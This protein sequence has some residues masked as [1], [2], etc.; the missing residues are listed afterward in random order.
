MSKDVARVIGMVI[1]VVSLGVFAFE[2][3]GKRRIL[4]RLQ[5][6][7]A[8]GDFE[9]ALRMLDGKLPQVLFPRYN[10]LFMRLNAL[11]A[12]DRPKEV[13]QLVDDVLAMRLPDRQRIAVLVKAFDYFVEKGDKKRAKGLLASIDQT[14]DE[15]ARRACHMAYDIFV[16]RSSQYIDD[17]ERA[18]DG[19]S[20]ADRLRMMQLLAVQYENR[21]DHEA[22]RRY[23]SQAEDLAVV[24]TKGKMGDER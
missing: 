12:L 3:I 6:M 8:D 1:I 2:T 7:L 5:R 18:L 13:A 22:A 16:S 23:A 24:L 9:G 10:Y 15:M 17:F 4:S 20:D 14:D 21:G 19:A 11:V